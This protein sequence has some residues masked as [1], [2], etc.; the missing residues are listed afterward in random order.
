MKN[1]LYK[2]ITPAKEIRSYILGLP[3]WLCNMSMANKNVLPRHFEIYDIK[4]YILL[5]IINCFRIL[6]LCITGNNL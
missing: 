4:V 3:S 5:I 2:S 6:S 1:P